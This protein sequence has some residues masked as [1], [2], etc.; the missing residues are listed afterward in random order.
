MALQ[1]SHGLVDESLNG[2]CRERGLFA[3]HLAQWRTDFCAVGGIG[4][5]RRESAPGGAG[6]EAGQSP[7]AAQLNRKE[8]A[9]A[10]AAALLVLQKKYRALFEGEAE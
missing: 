8:K 5:S 3:H 7:T 4:G 10:E 9:L 6:S 1:E 2:W